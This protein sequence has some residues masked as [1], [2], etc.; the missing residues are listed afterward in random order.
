[1]RRGGHSK[2]RVATTEVAYATAIHQPMQVP[3]LLNSL[4]FWNWAMLVYMLVSY[5]YPIAQFLFIDAP[6]AIPYG[7]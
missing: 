1:M 2:Q 3:H 5:G 4:S 7:Y 6:L